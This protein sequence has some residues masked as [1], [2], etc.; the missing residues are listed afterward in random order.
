MT[1]RISRWN[2]FILSQDHALHINSTI[3][4]IHFHRNLELTT[5]VLSFWDVI[6]IKL[7]GCSSPQPVYFLSTN[8]LS[9]YIRFIDIAKQN[10]WFRD[11]HMTYRFQRIFWNFQQA[12]FL[13]D[14]FVLWMEEYIDEYDMVNGKSFIQPYSRLCIYTQNWKKI[15]SRVSLEKSSSYITLQQ[16]ALKFATTTT[17]KDLSK[18]PRFN[19]ISESSVWSA[20][21][22]F[23]RLLKMSFHSSTLPFRYKSKFGHTRLFPI[24]MH[25]V[26]FG[27]KMRSYSVANSLHIVI[28][29]WCPPIV[30]H[31]SN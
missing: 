22:S 15:N 5:I 8:N 12:D 19:C 30:G 1:C 13:Y 18:W 31:S 16:C 10:N 9:V 25:A 4:S 26:L 7:H 2:T 20:F 29:F 21:M 3:I 11:F 6:T 14:F 27:L 23:P 24:A 28:I 17:K